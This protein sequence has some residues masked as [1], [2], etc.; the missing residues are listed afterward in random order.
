MA[1]TWQRR[2]ISGQ[3]VVL[4]GRISNMAPP[5][6]R[7]RAAGSSQR[8]PGPAA[9]GQEVVSTGETLL[10]LLGVLGLIP[11]A[12]LWIN[13]LAPMVGLGWLSFRGHLFFML[14]IYLI[15]WWLLTRKRR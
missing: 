15:P 10:I 3:F 5:D 2:V 4:R 6:N 7:R 14:G 13:V 8:T 9:Q 11:W 1:A 12:F